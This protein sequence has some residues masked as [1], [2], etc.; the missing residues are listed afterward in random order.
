MNTAKLIK[1]VRERRGQTQTELGKASSIPRVRIG[2]IERGTG[3][4]LLVT[5]FA[6]ISDALFLPNLKAWVVLDGELK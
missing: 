1:H 4:D 5:E 3:K 6:K 2:E